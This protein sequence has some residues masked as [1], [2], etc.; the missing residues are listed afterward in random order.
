[1]DWYKVYGEQSVEQM[2]TVE[3]FHLNGTLI[4]QQEITNLKSTIDLNDLNNGAYML[5][6]ISDN[7]VDTQ[8]FLEFDS[9]R[10]KTGEKKQ[11]I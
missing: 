10:Q 3:I 7:A 8:P 11:R 5:R 2:A 4:K 6:I 9:L 1:M